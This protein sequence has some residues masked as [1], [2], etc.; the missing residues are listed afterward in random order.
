VLFG[1]LVDPTDLPDH[2][3][4]VAAWGGALGRADSIPALQA[5]LST[6]DDVVLELLVRACGGRTLSL[7]WLRAATADWVAADP[8]ARQQVQRQLAAKIDSVLN[9][10]RTAPGGQE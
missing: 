8:P 7:G 1:R 9:P 6:S 2:D 3:S 10:A 5:W 4:I